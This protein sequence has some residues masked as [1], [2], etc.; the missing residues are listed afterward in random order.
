MRKITEF[1]SS[2]DGRFTGKSITHL[3]YPRGITTTPDG[4]IL[5]T[6]SKNIFMLKVAVSIDTYLLRSLYSTSN[7]PN[8]FFPNYNNWR[9]KFI[10]LFFQSKKVY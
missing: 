6:T 7:D 8:C 3:P 5:V 1:S 10:S 2:L 4:R 9:Q